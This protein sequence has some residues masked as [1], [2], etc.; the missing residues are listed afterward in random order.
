[1]SGFCG[2]VQRPPFALKQ[3]GLC[4]HTHF[5][6]CAPP[7]AILSYS[8]SIYNVDVKP[9]LCILNT[10]SLSLRWK[11]AWMVIGFY[12]KIEAVEDFDFTAK[13]NLHTA[14]LKDKQTTSFADQQISDLKDQA[15]RFVEDWP[16]IPSFQV[17]WSGWCS[18]IQSQNVTSSAKKKTDCHPAQWAL[19][20]QNVNCSLFFEMSSYRIVL[21]TWHDQ[22]RWCQKLKRR[23]NPKTWCE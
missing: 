11:M 5:Q 16:T 4:F 19:K 15:R 3:Q 20:C 1:M 7:L 9:S 10:A 8:F 17:A 23:W 13:K 21:Q 2:N 6:P 18:A 14:K 12:I 22:R